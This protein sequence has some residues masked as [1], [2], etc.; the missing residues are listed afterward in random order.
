M[1]LLRGTKIERLPSAR[2]ALDPG[3]RS[4]QEKTTNFLEKHTRRLVVLLSAGKAV[5]PLLGR[6]VIP[7]GLLEEETFGPGSR[8]KEHVQRPIRGGFYS[9]GDTRHLLRTPK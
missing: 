9:A 2:P 4:V 7:G 8:A 1:H 5:K 3:G 6:D